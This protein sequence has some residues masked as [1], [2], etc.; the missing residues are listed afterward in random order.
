MAHF[1]LQ[2]TPISP[3]INLN[4]CNEIITS[5]GGLF[6]LLNPSLTPRTIARQR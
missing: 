3:A 2:P 6:W 4:D 5:F 1:Q